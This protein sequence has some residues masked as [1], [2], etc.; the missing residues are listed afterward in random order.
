MIKAIV[1]LSGGMDSLLTAAIAAKEC[2]EL[3]FLHFAYGQRTQDK[4][5]DCFRAIA[6]HYQAKEASIVDYRWLADI[7]GSALTDS[8][9]Q[10]EQDPDG[11]PNTYV[12]FRNASM[13]SAAVA[14]AE[15]KTATRI[16]IGAVEEDSSGYPD[17][18]QS[19]FEAMQSVIRLGTKAANIRIHTPVLHMSKKDIV[20]K[21]MELNVPFELS[22]S[23]YKDSDA[24]CGVCPS[25]VLRLKAFAQAGLRDPIPY[26]E[27]S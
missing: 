4:E 23:C 19:F 21:G 13:L 9:I 16:Y 10:I 7:G 12:P 17:C 11:I 25:C 15:V 8:R 18:R 24:A 3:L 26:R 1:L 20:L 27:Q 5:Q 6:A 14:W 2:D 22:W